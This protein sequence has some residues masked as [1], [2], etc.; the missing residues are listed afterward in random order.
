MIVQSL[1]EDAN[2]K[3]YGVQFHPEVRHSEYGGNDLLR[4]FALMCV[5]VLVTGAWKTSSIWKSLKSV[6]K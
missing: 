2:R 1:L 4:H 3:F 6:N 5:A